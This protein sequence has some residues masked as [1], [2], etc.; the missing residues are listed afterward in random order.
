MLK[1]KVFLGNTFLVENGEIKKYLNDCPLIEIFDDCYIYLDSIITFKDHLDLY[2]I[3]L[4]KDLNAEIILK[5]EICG[6][7]IY[8]DKSSLIPFYCENISNNKSIKGIKDDVLLD[9][10][11]P[12]GM[13]VVAETITKYPKQRILKK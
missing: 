4:K 1:K 5:S 3:I 7:G 6:D 13:D 2:K 9:P 10:R 11:V 12:C 8:V